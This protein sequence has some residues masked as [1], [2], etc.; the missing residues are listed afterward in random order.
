[1]GNDAGG[2]KLTHLM[3]ESS[4]PLRAIK[5]E[6]ALLLGTL[7]F[8]LLLLPAAIYVVGSAY[9]GE[10]GEGG[11]KTFFAALHA[12]IRSM[13]AATWFL[14]LSPYLGIQVLRAALIAFRRL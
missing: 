11:F 6:A 8:G 4:P 2:K 9:F 3:N 5:F 1:M 10:S 14:V 12:D 13:D 7:L